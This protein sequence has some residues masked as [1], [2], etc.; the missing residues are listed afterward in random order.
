MCDC[1]NTEQFWRQ[2]NE[3]HARALVT[4]AIS[5]A[6]AQVEYVQ[7]LA[8]A[9]RAT[10]LLGANASRE[11]EVRAEMHQRTRNLHLRD[12]KYAFEQFATELDENGK[13]R[14]AASLQADRLNDFTQHLRQSITL[15][16][17]HSDITSDDAQKAVS[18]LDRVH[19]TLAGLTSWQGMGDYMNRHL[20][21]L[22]TQPVADA[23]SGLCVLVLL[24]SS[25][26][27]VLALIAALV[28]LGN[29]GCANQVLNQMINQA[30][31]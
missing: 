4:S 10:V 15:S 13:Q 5:A 6:R 27:V 16:L 23:A 19:A 20:D 2:V 8:T 28:C 9:K 24:L 30:C 25:V 3:A 21:E 31:P 12:T 26:L 14:I 17:L 18:A 1:G 11:Y 7:A 22:Q 29:Q